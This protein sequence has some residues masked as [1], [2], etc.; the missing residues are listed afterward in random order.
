MDSPPLSSSPVVRRFGGFEARRL[1]L[2][3]R[4]CADLGDSKLAAS[5]FFSGR[6][7][8]WGIRSSLPLSSSPVVCRF[9]RRGDFWLFLVV[10]GGGGGDLVVVAGGGGGDF[11]LLSPEEG[12]R[13]RLGAA[14]RGE[15]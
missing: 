10:A 2:L 4:S 6:A 5:L 8:I 14:R 13:P 3:L 12:A 15:R 1:S 9:E 11:W 7:L